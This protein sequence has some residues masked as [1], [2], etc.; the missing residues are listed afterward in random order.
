[1]NL[2]TLAW[3][4]LITKPSRFLFVVLMMA[5][6]FCLINMII[7]VNKQ[8]SQHFGK[9]SE[10]ADLILTAKGS[11]LQSVLCNLLHIDAPTG[12][13]AVSD[14]KSFLNPNHPLIQTAI[15]TSLG[16]SYQSH[17]LLGT[18]IEYFNHY[19]LEL[20]EGRLFENNFEAVVGAEAA[21]KADLQLGDEF[22][23]DHGLV[24]ES[25][26]HVHD[27]KLVVVGIL[28]SSG[29]VQ[30][31]L[32]YT[33]LSSY[34]LM[35]AGEENDHDHH[36]E[37]EADNHSHE[38]PVVNHTVQL[39]AFEDREITSVIL[40]MKGKNIQSLNFGR[41][42]NEN[43]N[44][45]A[46][47]PAI[48][49]NRLYELTGSASDVLYIIGLVLAVLTL[50]ALFINL[51]QVMDERKKEIAVIRLSGGSKITSVQLLVLEV[52]FIMIIG[53]LIGF[54]M[55][56]VFLEFGSRYLGL[57]EKYQ[58]TGFYFCKEE[59]Q[60]AALALFAAL[61]ASMY[62]IWKAY[63]QDVSKTLSE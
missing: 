47:N 22:F 50:V 27:K 7:L 56:H 19:Q 62:P 15:P 39:P 2:L 51:L 36:H 33:N 6:A 21:L 25:G 41:Q 60:I 9:S 23:S 18:A 14:A 59:I 49:I 52:L 37:H 24:S 13:I 8:F 58:I 20:N 3:K 46:V 45:L 43:T 5:I 40:K 31:R 32:I 17:R 30:D 44:L 16:D 29:K 34:W 61:I 63:R 10:G 57:G 53:L 1:M 55:T 28:K 4:N 12:N 48:E 11:P 26:A 54:I 38:E 35:H 42:I